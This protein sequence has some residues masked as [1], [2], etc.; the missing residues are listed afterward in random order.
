[1]VQ[2]SGNRS[3]SDFCV[4]A[5]LEIEEGGGKVMCC[6]ILMNNNYK[7]TTILMAMNN[8]EI[9]S[10]RYT[11]LLYGLSDDATL[12]MYDSSSV[13]NVHVCQLSSIACS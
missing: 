8:I 2:R 9:Y 1:M 11:V 12:Y 6:A 3:G 13:S 10:M 7:K 5:G 4:D